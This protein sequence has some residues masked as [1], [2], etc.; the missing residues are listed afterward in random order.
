MIILI[1]LEIIVISI[2]LYYYLKQKKYNKKLYSRSWS[3]EL[4]LMTIY[5]NCKPTDQEL[6][7]KVLEETEPL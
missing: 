7:L 6:I 2:L 4:V 1:V 5:N 3:Y